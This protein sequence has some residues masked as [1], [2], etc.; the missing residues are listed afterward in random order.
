MK[1][2]FPPIAASKVTAKHRAEP[3]RRT[4]WQIWFGFKNRVYLAFRSLRKDWECLREDWFS[5][6]EK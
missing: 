3:N 1:K 6:K 2:A 4:W 5:W